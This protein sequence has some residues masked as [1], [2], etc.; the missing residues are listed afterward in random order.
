MKIKY[1]LSRT[2]GATVVTAVLWWSCRRRVFFPAPRADTTS[3]SKLGVEHKGGGY[4]FQ[5]EPERPTPLLDYLICHSTYSR[6]ENLETRPTAGRRRVQSPPRLPPRLHF[7]RCMSKLLSKLLS[8]A[9]LI[10]LGVLGA[11]K[12]AKRAWR[13]WAW[14]HSI[15]PECQSCW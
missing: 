10:P 12:R 1:I 2:V 8:T 15:G 13:K 6:R 7:D 5:Y 3:G 4:F 11:G 9:F 14:C